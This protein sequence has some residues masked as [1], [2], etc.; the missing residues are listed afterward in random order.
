MIG[1]RMVPR[2]IYSSLFLDH[3]DSLW[4][5]Q[6]LKLKNIY[7][8][9]QSNKRHLIG[10]SLTG[11]DL[12]GGSVQ[13]LTNFHMLLRSSESFLAP[14]RNRREARVNNSFT[15]CRCVCI[16]PTMCQAIME[17]PS[18]SWSQSSVDFNFRLEIFGRD[19]KGGSSEY[20]LS[21]FYSN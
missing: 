17:H 13:R 8:Y 5:M 7:I 9:H 2:K 16:V 12:S 4:S 15:V 10:L 3:M 11:Q 18:L 1:E 19:E 14:L 21:F 20:Q 6:L